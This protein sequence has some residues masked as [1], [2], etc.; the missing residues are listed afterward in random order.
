MEKSVTQKNYIPLVKAKGLVAKV[1]PGGDFVIYRK[2]QQS[3]TADAFCDRTSKIDTSEKPE[4]SD[5]SR[6][7]ALG[8]SSLNNSDRSGRAMPRYGLKGITTK[9]RRNIRAA[10]WL[11]ERSVGCSRISLTTVTIPNLPYYELKIIHENWHKVVEIYRLNLR[12]WL[13]RKGLRGE[14]V[15]CTEVQEKREDS[16]GVP[17]LHLHCVFVGR[18]AGKSWA[19]SPTIHDLMWARV[20]ST[21]LAREVTNISA[22]CK[23]ERA[24]SGAHIYLSKY[25]SKG[26]KTIEKIVENEQAEWLPKQWWNCSKTLQKKVE[27]TTAKFSNGARELLYILESKSGDIFCQWMRNRV[28]DD[29]GRK[30]IELAVYGRLLPFGFE[31]AKSSWFSSENLTEY[32]TLIN[33]KRF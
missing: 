17:S 19:L 33:Q 13:K 3:E 21:V 30:P 7:G 22:A 5:I 26:S 27:N 20:L 8:L 4:N 9:G 1:W 14:I 29:V 24:R 15:G 31:M 18:K 2:R 6:C 16:T 11:M 23:I 28:D 32:A 10:V 12:R 25:L